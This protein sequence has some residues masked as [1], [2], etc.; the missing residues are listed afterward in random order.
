MW[1]GPLRL[2]GA[3]SDGSRHPELHP[4]DHRSEAHLVCS[5]ALEARHSAPQAARGGGHR[6]RGQADTWPP[7]ATWPTS[8]SAPAWVL[9]PL[10]QASPRRTHPS[11]RFL[12]GG[13]GW[14]ESTS[15]VR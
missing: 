8:A 4:R 1:A 14:A 11:G 5:S 12:S 6:S 3:D 2:G 9:L 7:P 13:G 15:G 10:V